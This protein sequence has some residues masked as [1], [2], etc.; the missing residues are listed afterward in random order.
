MT[1]TPP[2]TPPTDDLHAYTVP[3]FA[4]RMRVTPRT[5]ENRIKAGDIKA[6]KLGRSVRIPASELARVLTPA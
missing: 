4:R 2:P 6:V 1:T 5:I 3:E